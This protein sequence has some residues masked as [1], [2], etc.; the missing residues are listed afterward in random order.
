HATLGVIDMQ[1]LCSR[2]TSETLFEIAYSKF[3]NKMRWHFHL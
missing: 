1:L 3:S 2:E